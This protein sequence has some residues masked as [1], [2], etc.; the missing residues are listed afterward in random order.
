M[1]NPRFTPA[2]SARAPGR[3]RLWFA[4]LGGGSAWTL[5][6][7]LAYVIAEFGCLSGFGERRLGGFSWVAWM[8]LVLS[9]LALTLALSATIFSRRLQRGA[10]ADSSDE[11]ENASTVAFSGRLAF[12]TNLVF[13]AVIAVQSVPIFYFLG[14]C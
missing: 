6:L 12:I 13:T 9:V 7:L 10:H 1:V 4:L 11:P 14:R 5:H 3:N 8:L 2:S